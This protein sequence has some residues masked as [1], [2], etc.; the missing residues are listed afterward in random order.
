ME[1]NMSKSLEL[2]NANTV[3]EHLSKMIGTSVYYVDNENLIKYSSILGELEINYN[4]EEFFD[5]LFMDS[6]LC[7]YPIIR[8]KTTGEIFFAINLFF[9]K[10]NEGKF[11][12]GPFL[13]PQIFSQS[14]YSQSSKMKLADK[15]NILDKIGLNKIIS[16][17]IVC[18]YLIYNKW[19]D[20]ETIIKN[21]IKYKELIDYVKLNIENY[22]MEEK[23][24]NFYY[25]VLVF[26]K[27]LAFAIMKGNKKNIV[28]LL[29]EYQHIN[30]NILYSNDI[31]KNTKI[32]GICVISGI[33]KVS[34]ENHLNYI[35][36]C[37]VRDFY[38]NKLESLNELSKINNLIIEMVYDFVQRINEMNNPNKYTYTIAKCKDFIDN[39]IYDKITSSDISSH[40]GLNASYFS[41]KFKHEVG[42]SPTQY[43]LSSKIQEAKN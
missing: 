39:H 11:I 36:A 24:D 42:I 29:R 2:F 25:N 33:S 16:T 22:K 6:R 12:V 32:K 26:E 23:N 13:Y 7:K 40:F 14:F 19:L 37:C 27:K 43:I 10:K 35:T 41:Q 8:F 20:E 38:I 4:S 1:L 5:K 31:I 28:K 21:N 15:K 9:N 17:C 34:M 3:C 30:T 18:Y